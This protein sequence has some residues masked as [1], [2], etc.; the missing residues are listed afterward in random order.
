MTYYDNYA[1]DFDLRDTNV[2]HVN[3]FGDWH[4]DMSWIIAMLD[5]VS[6]GEVTVQVGDLGIGFHPNLV[7][8]IS[9]IAVATETPFLFIDG[10]HENFDIL[11]Q[12]PV[13]EDGLRELAP[14]MFHIPRG[15]TWKWGDERWMGLGGAH[16]VDRP[17]R[18]TYIDWWPQEHLTEREVR[19]AMD[20][21]PIDVL[22]TH[23][24]SDLYQIP[25]L[26]SAAGAFPDQELHLADHHRHL[27]SEVVLA[28]TPKKQYHGHYH[29]YYT[30][31]IEDLSLEIIG[32]DM[33]RSEI[34]QHRH[35]HWTT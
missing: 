17:W 6:D 2:N 35:V 3:I 22:I 29:R 12:N 31:H 5:S 30:K 8:T 14:G 21:G 24:A 28:T 32:L 13:R 11:Y 27:I 20:A 7:N 33:N 4:A 19:K 1:R 16:S 9:D 10:N 23:D 18:R 15:L 34:D 25:D 26:P